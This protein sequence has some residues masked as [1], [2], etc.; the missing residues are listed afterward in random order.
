MHADLVASGMPLHRRL[1]R[2][3]VDVPCS[4]LG[5]IRRHPEIKW[6]T[7]PADLQRNAKTQHAILRTCPSHQ[8]AGRQLPYVPCSPQ[9]AEPERPDGAALRLL[10]AELASYPADL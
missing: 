1:A 8:E 9:A 5:T 4:G 7:T 6:H 2:I 3:L 10:D